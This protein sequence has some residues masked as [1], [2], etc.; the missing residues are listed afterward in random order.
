MSTYEYNWTWR[1]YLDK[2]EHGKRVSRWSSSQDDDLEFRGTR[3]YAEA[4]NFA[5]FGWK[6]GREELQT[7]L[8]EANQIERQEI[9]PATP[10]DLAGAF[11]NVPVYCAG[12]EFC[13][14]SNEPEPIRPVIRLA[15]T[16]KANAVT[17][18]RYYLNYGAAL[19]SFIQQ[20]ELAGYRVELNLLMITQGG[21]SQ[22]RALICVKE[23]D[24][25]IEI[26]RLAYALM[27]RSNQRRLWFAIIEQHLDFAKICGVGYGYSVGPKSIRNKKFL[28][29]Y[30]VIDGLSNDS[31]I[32]DS[33]ETIEGAV[34]AIEKEI[35]KILE[36]ISLP[37][38]SC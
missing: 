32:K 17:S 28:E 31:R 8:K 7:A 37:S 16:V 2:A 3:T 25:E 36:K 29:G 18:A 38:Q 10:L 27:N 6:E 14:Y 11:P 26:D 20:L 23:A 30:H 12:D 9:D 35:E 5:R 21:D 15:V 34:N 33:M 1:Q 13:M 22:M 19:C 4:I 24:Q